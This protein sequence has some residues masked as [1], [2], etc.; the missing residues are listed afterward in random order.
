MIR[1]I[2]SPTLCVIVVHIHAR[3]GPVVIGV[4]GV[5]PRNISARKIRP[6]SHLFWR[7]KSERQCLSSTLSST[8][9]STSGSP[10]SYTGFDRRNTT[11]NANQPLHI[12]L[13]IVVS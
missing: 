7:I 3:S 5:H 11:P 12:A 10:A 9:V 6:E 4:K 8:L 1:N 2:G 13:D